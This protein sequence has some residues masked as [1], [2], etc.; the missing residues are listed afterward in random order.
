MPRLMHVP[1]KSV[2]FVT[3]QSE[4]SFRDVI[5]CILVYTDVLEEPVL[6]VIRED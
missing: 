5:L 6:S 1:Y 3:V 4:V 2:I